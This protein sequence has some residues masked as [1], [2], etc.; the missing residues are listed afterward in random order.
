[1]LASGACDEQPISQGN[2]QT[3]HMLM[4]SQGPGTRAQFLQGGTPGCSPCGEWLGVS[5]RSEHQ[6]GGGVVGRME[7]LEGADCVLLLTSF[8][9][10]C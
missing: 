6:G 7:W 3:D 10:Y 5:L 8:C 2:K 1:M 9:M 4:C